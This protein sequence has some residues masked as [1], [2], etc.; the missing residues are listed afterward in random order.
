[1]DTRPAGPIGPIVVDLKDG[2][3]YLWCRCGRSASQP[4]CDGS[5]RGTGLQPMVFTP[6]AD[7]K[8]RM[9]LCKRTRKPPFCDGSHLD[10]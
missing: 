7:M 5:H 8:V 9:C 1:M 2:K 6:S 3:T 4:L 10:I